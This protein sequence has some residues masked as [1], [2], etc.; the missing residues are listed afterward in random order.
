MDAPGNA[1]VE[2]VDG[3]GAAARPD[4]SND[5]GLDPRRLDLHIHRRISRNC[6]EQRLERRNALGASSTSRTDGYR[7]DRIEH[8]LGDDGDGTRVARPRVR[9]RVVVYDDD[10]IPRCVDVELDGV[11]AVR[12]CSAERSD[13]VFAVFAG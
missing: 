2:A 9:R 1:V 5:L 7:L 4:D 3:T 8:R 13:R 11:G 12:E 10:A 6:F